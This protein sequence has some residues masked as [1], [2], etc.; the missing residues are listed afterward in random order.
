MCLQTKGLCVVFLIHFIEL[1]TDCR[2]SQQAEATAGCCND[3]NWC[4]STVD[5]FARDAFVNAVA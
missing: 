2:L 5:G 4:V 3:I 1:V